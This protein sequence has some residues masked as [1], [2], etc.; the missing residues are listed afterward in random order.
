MRHIDITKIKLPNK[1]EAVAQKY[2]QKMKGLTKNERKILINKK[3]HV[4]K[5]LKKSLQE[6]SHNKCWYCES[7]QIR[8]DNPVD[9]YRP[10]NSVK[11]DKSHFGYWWLAFDWKNY[12]YCCT[13]CNSQR[14]DSKTGQLKGKG[15]SFPI[16]NKSNRCRCE[17]DPL[18]QE[19]PLLLDPTVASDPGLLYFIETGEAVPKFDEEKNQK[20]Y[21]RAKISI[22][23]YHLNEKD[24]K[25][26]RQLI[27]NEIKKIID[28]G[29]YYY[30]IL[31]SNEG[32]T[33]FREI[34]TKLIDY[35]KP[36]SE[37]S[38]FAKTML[39]GHCDKEWILNFVLRC[40]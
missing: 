31:N 24:I 12:R 11:E 14:K 18:L 40:S 33:G 35:I 34:L 30:L 32:E 16:F 22:D 13:F 37:Y 38:A 28:D 39:M 27:S 25:D 3:S 19:K 4:W 21:K 15:D 5:N 23:L 17:R 8:S 9:H 36:E 26:K 20:A 10:K 7:S 29:N 2:S 1:W 6:L